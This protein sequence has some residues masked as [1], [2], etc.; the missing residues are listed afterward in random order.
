MGLTVVQ[1]NRMG[2]LL[3]PDI[4]KG[5]ALAT[6]K[7]HLGAEQVKVL[8]LGDSP[9]IC[10]CSRWLTSLSW[11]PGPMAPIPRCVPGSLPG[12]SSWRQPPCQ[13]LG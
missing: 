13:R 3:G 6:L 8:A 11:C 2:H 4:S 12:V 7:R 10:R 5:K 1:G 9:T